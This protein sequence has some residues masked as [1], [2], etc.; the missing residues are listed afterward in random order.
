ML[1]RGFAAHKG[2]GQTALAQFVSASA[3][4]AGAAR[5]TTVQ[6]CAQQSRTFTTRSHS[7][8]YFSKQSVRAFRVRDVGGHASGQRSFNAT[9][10]SVVC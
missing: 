3:A 5:P 4:T 10:R 9:A 6:T 1:A 2:A 7:S 8:F